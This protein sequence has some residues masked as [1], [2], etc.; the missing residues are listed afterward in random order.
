[1]GL[2][3]MQEREGECEGRSYDP[4]NGKTIA[5]LERS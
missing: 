2:E 3:D 4:R 5:L 1:M